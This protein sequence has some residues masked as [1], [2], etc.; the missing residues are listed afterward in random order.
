LG[1][2]IFCKFSESFLLLQ[3]LLFR[4]L[5]FF[6]GK[7]S[8][9][10]DLL[11]LN[12]EYRLIGLKHILSALDDLIVPFQF[13]TDFLNPFVL[14]IDKFIL[15]LPE[16]EYFFEFLVESFLDPDNHVLHHDDL[17][18]LGVVRKELE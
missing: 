1:R 14:I 16:L 5:S 17:V 2:I 7:K 4:F 9:K 11:G 12:L 8:P 18:A 10:R 13:F 6:F 15:I 3:S